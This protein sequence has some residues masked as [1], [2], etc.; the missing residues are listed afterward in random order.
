[1]IIWI[2]GA[3]GVGKSSIAEEL[4]HKID[5]SFVYDPEQVGYFLWDNF[6]D[7]MRR[8]GNFQ[9]IP[10]WR[11]FNYKILKYV[12]DSYDGTIIVPMT[13]Y[14]KQYYDEIIGNLIKN[15]VLIRHFILSATKATILERLIK[16]GEDNEN[17]AMQHVDACIKAFDKFNAFEE[18]MPNQKIDTENKSIDDIVLEILS[19]SNF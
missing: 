19:L 15:N 12:N 6:P 1:M 8:T 14:I 3:F 11:E 13:I 17:W 5:A 9:H 16:R 4:N 18:D 10:I 2:N 7:E